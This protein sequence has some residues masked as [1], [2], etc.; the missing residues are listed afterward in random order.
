MK[1]FHRLAGASLA[2]SLAA[3]GALDPLLIP[4]QGKPYIYSPQEKAPR[5]G[6]HGYQVGATGQVSYCSSEG[7]VWLLNSRRKKALDAI[8]EVCGGENQYRIQ[9]EINDRTML[10]GTACERGTSIVFKCL[11]AE[12]SYDRRK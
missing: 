9:G 2:L 1:P 5:I 8:A 11:G 10:G 6:S 3:C 12:P 7:N 4:N